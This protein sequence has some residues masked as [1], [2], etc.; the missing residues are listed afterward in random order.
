MAAARPSARVGRPSARVGR[1]SARFGSPSARLEVLRRGRL[2]RLQVSR[3][4][5]VLARLLYSPTQWS[6][7][8]ALPRSREPCAECNPFAVTAVF[9]LSFYIDQ[10]SRGGG[11]GALFSTKNNTHVFCVWEG[12]EGQL[13]C[14]TRSR[15]HGNWH[16][17]KPRVTP[18]LGN[19]RCTEV[20]YIAQVT[21]A[22]TTLSFSETRVHIR[23]ECNGCT[24]VRCDLEPLVH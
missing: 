14:W 20:E 22:A 8:L 9:E 6:V 17:A 4:V 16:G 10:Q 5:L 2:R 7:A 23:V 1:P 19:L 21:N 18:D 11:G 13:Q 12:R 3:R 24:I 15:R